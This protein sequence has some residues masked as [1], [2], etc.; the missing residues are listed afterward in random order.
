M[1][2]GLSEC[3]STTKIIR[4]KVIR[5]GETETSGKKK[6][7]QKKKAGIAGI[8]ILAVLLLT[9]GLVYFV[10]HRYYAKTNYVSDEEAARQ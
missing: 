2:G 8:V 10:G 3:Q 4:K 5:W 7:S 9:A 6:M 1:M